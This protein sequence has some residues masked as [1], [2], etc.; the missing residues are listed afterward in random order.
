MS[1]QFHGWLRHGTALAGVFL[2]GVALAFP[3]GRTITKDRI[4]LP[5][6]YGK[7]ILQDVSLTQDYYH[8]LFS[9]TITNNTDRNWAMIS[10]ILEFS[11]KSGGQIPRQAGV[12]TTVRIPRLQKGAAR[13][14][15]ATIPW[16]IMYRAFRA[17]TGRIGN[18]DVIYDRA[19]SEYDLLYV[20]ALTKPNESDKLAFEDDSIRIAFAVIESQ[21]QFS[22]QNRTE[23]PIEVNW[24]QVS[25]IDFSG[26]S[27]RVIHAGT[28]FND[29]EK[30]QAPATVPPTA[31]IEDIVYPAD[32]AEWTGSDWIHS[33]ILPP[34]EFAYKGN[35]FSVFVPLKINGEL[36]NYL[37]TVKVADVRTQ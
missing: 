3:K 20:L 11:D 28:K 12:D 7:F 31:R 19:H 24:D 22:L 14:I 18:F 33:P 5:T 37:F 30:P 26:R 9:G 4:E 23:S 29:R 17:P 6:E 25:F 36:K 35:T 32:Y 34:A 16:Q 13:P 21:I 8:V 15:S 27:H 1:F 10:L 2:M